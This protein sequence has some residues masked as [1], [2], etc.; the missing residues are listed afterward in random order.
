MVRGS[1]EEG[2]PKIE[3]DGVVLPFQVFEP[4]VVYEHE[5]GHRLRLTIPLAAPCRLE[6]KNGSEGV[7]RPGQWSVS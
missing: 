5:S 7:I 4:E 1:I 3:L 6:I 2:Y